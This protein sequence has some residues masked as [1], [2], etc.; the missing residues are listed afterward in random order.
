M[1]R[2]GTSLLTKTLAELGLFVGEDLQDDHESVFFIRLNNRLLRQSGSTWDYPERY[3]TMVHKPEWLL[4]QVALTRRYLRGR[5]AARYAGI[6]YQRHFRSDT[7]LN[8]PWGW[9]DPRNTI[10]LPLWMHLYPEAKIIHIKR[11]GID[12]AHSLYTRERRFARILASLLKAVGSQWPRAS[13]GKFANPL[14]CNKLDNTFELWEFYTAQAHA[15]VRTWKNQAVE[16][17]Y[18]DFLLKPIETLEDICHFLG[19]PINH[20]VISTLPSL[21]NVNRAFAYR[22]NNALQEYATRV[23]DRLEALGYSA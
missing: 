16:I 20:A 21:V 8:Q 1:H 14:R 3:Q 15:H 6:K 11:H 12:V 10:T 19:L 7:G 18:E 2:S 5:R 9:K 22:K 4:R 23:R 13:D 17:S